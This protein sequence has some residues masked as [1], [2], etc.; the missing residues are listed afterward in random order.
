[1]KK[2]ITIISLIS[3]LNAC[4]TN[5]DCNLLGLCNKNKCECLQGW[6]G[7]TCDKPDFKPINLTHG[8]VNESSY[9]W[10]GNMFKGNDDKY[11]LFCTE[12]SNH[13]EL[14]DFYNNS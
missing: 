14:P 11:H 7:E 4:K 3:I 9:S 13:C 1:M 12:M 2:I 8:Y 10:G 6:K 5:L